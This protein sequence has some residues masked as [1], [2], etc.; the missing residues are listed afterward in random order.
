[1]I[2]WSDLK[3]QSSDF[4]V[5]EANDCELKRTGNKIKN[6]LVSSVGSK[7]I[8]KGENRGGRIVKYC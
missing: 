5:L 4:S 8:D 6:E 2:I 1:M 3:F 7:E